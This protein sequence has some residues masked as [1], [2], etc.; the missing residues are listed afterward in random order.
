M[1][2]PGNGLIQALLAVAVIVAS[3]YS[4]G[5]IHQWYRDGAARE[6]AYRHG[7]DCA[8]DGMLDMALRKQAARPAARPP[9]RAPDL[10]VDRTAGMRFPADDPPSPLVGHAR[11][12]NVAG[13]LSCAG[14]GTPAR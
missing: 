4:L 11:R 13:E 6:L 2:A 14:P 1:I 5:R 9:A 12:R 7:Y 8:S 10:Q 3:G